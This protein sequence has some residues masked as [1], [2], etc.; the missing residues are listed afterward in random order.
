MPPNSSSSCSLIHPWLWVIRS[1]S[2]H[3]L[4]F[5]TVWAPGSGGEAWRSAVMGSSVNHL[6]QASRGGHSEQTNNSPSLGIDKRA[7]PSLC[8]KWNCRVD[9]GGD[10]KWICVTE[11]TSKTSQK[12]I[13]C[14]DAADIFI[15]F[16]IVIRTF[17]ESELIC[18]SLIVTGV[19]RVVLHKVLAPPLL[20]P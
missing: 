20:H 13:S 11:S 18:R 4:S 2:M 7:Q 14:T 19:L 9:K 10:G 8:F 17:T 6:D 12:M 15:T 3:W 5:L 16:W 1:F